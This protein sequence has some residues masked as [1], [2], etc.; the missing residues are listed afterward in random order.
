M[1]IFCSNKISSINI[2]L[3]MH[4]LSSTLQYSRIY[5]AYEDNYIK[6]KVFV[7]LLDDIN[8]YPKWKFTCDL[9][10]GEMSYSC[11]SWLLKVF[12]QNLSLHASGKIAYCATECFHSW[13]NGQILIILSWGQSLVECLRTLHWTNST[14]LAINDFHENI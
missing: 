14:F 10:K 1:P 11:M 6:I 3:S 5:I 7:S 12:E 8:H 2:V 4:T 13:L 9:F